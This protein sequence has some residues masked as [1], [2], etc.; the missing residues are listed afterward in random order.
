MEG[1]VPKLRAEIKHPRKGSCTLL[2]DF[3]GESIATA[4]GWLIIYC[5]P[6]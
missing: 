2:L 5:G 1:T 6:H 3:D 4:T